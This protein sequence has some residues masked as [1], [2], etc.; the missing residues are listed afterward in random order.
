M[1]R[2]K[3]AVKITAP[4]I[5]QIILYSVP[6]IENGNG[7]GRFSSLASQEPIKAPM[8]PTTIESMQPPRSNPTKDFAIPPAIPAIIREMR[9]SIIFEYY[10]LNKE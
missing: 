4:T 1:I 5:V 8:N 7:S 9:M 2:L 6:L 10:F 3:S